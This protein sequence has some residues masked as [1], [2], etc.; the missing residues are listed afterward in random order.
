MTINM[1]RVFC[2]FLTTLIIFNAVQALAK[3]KEYHLTITKESVNF[4]GRPAVAMTINHQI[5]GP[6]LRFTEGDLARIHVLNKTN[7]S[8]SIHWHGLLVPPGMDGVPYISF[9][10]IMPGRSFT[11]EFPI[12]QSGTYWYH[13]HSGLQEQMGVYGAIAIDPV[14]PDPKSPSERVILLSD[15]T[16][17]PPETVMHNLRRGSEWH[18]LQKGAGQSI[19]GALKAGKL[20]DY[21]ARELG[22]MPAMDISD[23]AYDRF[24]ANG[25][26]VLNLEAKPGQTLRLRVVNGS[27]TTFLCL[28]LPQDP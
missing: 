27:A 2:F 19:F 9:P 22:R 23:V 15:W 12:R 14:H 24:L 1:K 3:I 25:K 5:P 13:S 20:G 16:D 8:T 10:P 6:V 7:T 4:T 18:P 21:F 11:Y 28:I 26:P 17:E